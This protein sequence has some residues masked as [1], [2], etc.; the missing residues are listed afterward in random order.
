MAYEVYATFG[1][2]QPLGAEFLLVCVKCFMYY[3]R[4]V[5]TI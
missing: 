3:V 4:N 5:Y 1:F 2:F